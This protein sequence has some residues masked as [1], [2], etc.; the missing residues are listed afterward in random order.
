MGIP[1]S[2][3]PWSAG[4]STSLLCLPQDPGVISHSPRRLLLLGLLLDGLLWETLRGPCWSR[5]L[6]LLCLSPLPDPS[7]VLVASQPTAKSHVSVRSSACGSSGT[8]L[9][10]TLGSV[11][12]LP[13]RL[14]RGLS[15]VPPSQVNVGL[16]VAKAASWL[17]RFLPTPVPPLAL[18]L[19][20][21][22]LLFHT[23]LHLCRLLLDLQLHHIE[24]ALDLHALST[25]LRVPPSAQIGLC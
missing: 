12:P 16:A 21:R 9:Q 14:R 15:S 7:V 25:P 13:P 23:C 4:A 2:A 19:P 8:T 11:L 20:S 6:L 18:D 3:H 24:V 17:P 5:M 1:Q 10:R 22:L